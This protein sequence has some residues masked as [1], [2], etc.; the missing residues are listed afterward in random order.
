[1]SQRFSSIVS[2][3]SKLTP[4]VYLVTFDLIEPKQINFLAGQ[5]VMFLVAPGINRSMS[6]ASPPSQKNQITMVHDIS[7]MGVFSRW[8]LAAKVGDKLDFMGPLG[9]FVLDKNQPR[10]IIMLATSTGIAPFRSILLDYLETGGKNEVM[11]YWGLRFVEDL[12][13]QDELERLSKKYINFHYLVTLTQA[14]DNWT[15]KQGRI[16]EHLFTSGRNF[17]DSDFYLCGNRE[18]VNEVRTRLSANNVPKEQI[19][20]ELFY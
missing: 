13:W 4:R 14:S 17:Q 1:M 16:G 5:T 11:L 20:Y 12:F 15:G 19:K 9:V 7:P 6:I 3:K 8:T 18:M 2:A 10:R